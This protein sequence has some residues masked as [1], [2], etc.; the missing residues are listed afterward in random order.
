M[1]LSLAPDSDAE[2]DRLAAGTLP[3]P[4]LL[5]WMGA[6]VG[7][8]VPAGVRLGVFDSLAAAPQTA[9]E[10]ADALGL[11]RHG[12]A[13]LL[14]GLA[15]FGL[16]ER[17]AG[18]FR[19]TP[20]AAQWLTTSS[21]MCVA[22]MLAL[23]EDI[24]GWLGG[25]E[26]GVRT[27][28]VENFHF[29]TGD[30][31]W[32]NYLGLLTV[33]AKFQAPALAQSLPVGPGPRRLLDLAGGPGLYTIAAAQAHPELTIDVLELEPSAAEGRKNVEAAGLVGRVRYH[34]GDLFDRP[35]P[36][37]GYD[38]ILMS[39]FLHCLPGDRCAGVVRK[40]AAH[41]APGGT[42]V[43]HDVEI[44]GPD[45]K[46]T[47]EQYERWLRDAGLTGVTGSR[48]PTGTVLVTGVRGD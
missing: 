13:V 1:F 24:H 10:V 46:L 35:W 25:L 23:M 40:A 26:A 42:A 7:R 43:V 16:L 19:P 38:L 20:Q 8:L 31:G 32:R 44:A 33:S 17:E 30:E 5:A 2:R 12:T 39:H 6:V 48:L 27:G 14:E 3:A 11:D 29:R 45:G 37:D 28:R 34:V 4:M 22:P 41:L 9:D 47:A 36:G 21:P 18:L 15:G